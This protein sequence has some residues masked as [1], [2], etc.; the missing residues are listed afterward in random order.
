MSDRAM[1]MKNQVVTDQLPGENTAAYWLRIEGALYG[2]IAGA[3]R[4]ILPPDRVEARE[5][6]Q[7]NA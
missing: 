7:K 5:G 2:A 1:T 3:P 4:S 6:A